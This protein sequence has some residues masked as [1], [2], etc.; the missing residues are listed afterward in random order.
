MFLRFDS[1]EFSLVDKGNDFCRYSGVFA[2]PGV[3][4]YDGVSELISDSELF[5]DST[6]NSFKGVPMVV[7]HPADGV[8]TSGNW[9]EFSVGSVGDVR[10]I[11]GKLWGEFVI[12]DSLTN[13]KIQSGELVE[14]SICRL[15][16]V[17]QE[18]GTYNG[19]QYESA[20]K[21]L[22]GNHVA[23]TAKG[24]AG[25]DARIVKRLDSEV[26]M[27]LRYR[28]DSDG[29]DY[30]VSEAV[31]KDLEALKAKQEELKKELDAKGKEVQLP[32][33]ELDSIKKQIVEKEALLNS[34]KLEVDA[35]KK[36]FEELENKIPS[37]VDAS[38]KER[39]EVVSQAGAVLGDS[40]NFDSLSVSQIKDQ[41]IAKVLPYPDD[42]RSDSISD[43]VRDAYF[44]AAIKLESKKASI[45][46][47]TV[48]Q[49]SVSDYRYS[50]HNFKGGK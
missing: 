37:I 14:L 12:Y 49:D 47:V 28:A 31:F 43:S 22:R 2:V 44:S 30:E 4:I 24:R 13:Q 29:K 25:K 5:S 40:V 6:I 18:S 41:V 3:L 21:N 36:K 33:P 8:V 20:Q 17:V 26:T 39:L 46:P 45:N 1:A 10:V 50:M 7:E 16:E 9:K 23:I 38:A 48:K 35:W 19:I 42:L 15:A 32:V 11:D 27:P 34:A